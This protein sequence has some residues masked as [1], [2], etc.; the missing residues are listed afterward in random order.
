[1]ELVNLPKIQEQQRK[2]KEREHEEQD[3]KEL[4]E[5]HGEEFL[6]KVLSEFSSVF[7]FR[8]FA[9]EDH[10]LKKERDEYLERQYRE[11]LASLES[12]ETAVME[13]RAIKKKNELLQVLRNS[14]E[15]EKRGETNVVTF[16]VQD[17]A[18]SAE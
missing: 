13:Q 1:M 11:H 9:P 6:Q 16:P 2:E 10:P 5:N 4:S 14:V 17:A 18:A 8:F 3:R 7:E 15:R 12:Y